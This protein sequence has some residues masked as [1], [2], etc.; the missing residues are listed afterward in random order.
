MRDRPVFDLFLVSWLVLFLELACIRWF[1][2]HVLFLTFFTNTVLL[3]CFVGMSIGCVVARKPA[4]HIARTP[5]LLAVAVGCGL[6][7]DLFSQ[8]LQYFV[9][10]GNQKNPEVVFFGTEVNAASQTEYHVP[11]ELIAAV[12]FGLIAAVMV[13]PG[14]EMGRAFNRVAGRTRAYSV[15]LLGSLAGIVT[16]AA[17][18][19]LELPPVAWFAAAAAGVGYFAL[20]PVPAGP[21]A[22]TPAAAAAPSS[23]VTMLM[24]LAVAVLL[25]VPTSGLVDLGKPSRTGWSPYYRI[26]HFPKE[27][28]VD[29]NRVSHQVMISRTAP[30]LAGYALPYLFQRDVPLADP[31]HKAWPPFRRVLIIG[32]G[33]GNDL[34]RALQWCP[35]DAVIDAVEIDPRIQRTGAAYHPD[36]PYKD[37]RVR[38]HIN[39]GRNFLRK[40]PAAEYDL[41]VFALVDSLVLHSGYSNLRLESYLFTTESFAD[42]RRVL[43]PTGLMAVYNFFRQG[44]LAARL[45][46]QMRAVYGADP[47]VLMAPPKDLIPL[48][49]FDARGFTAFF[50]GSAEV[51]DPLKRAFRSADNSFWLPIKFPVGTDAPMGFRRDQP[52]SP[53]GSSMPVSDLRLEDGLPDWGR[54][55]MAEVEDSRGALKLATDDW[56][57]L[58]VRNP[59]VPGHTWRGMGL[60]VLM[61]GLL[62]LVY[63]RGGRGETSTA[64][65]PAGPWEAG[66]FARSFFLGAGFMLVETKAVVQMA[67]LFGSTWMVNTVVFAAILVMALA[68]NLFA[69][70][71]NPRRLEPYYVGLFAALAAGLAIPVDAFLGMDRAVQIAGACALAFA[72]VAF[73]GVVFAASFR[74]TRRPDQMI[75]AN[76]A[77]ALVGGL[78]ENASIVLGFQYL[79]CVAVAFYALSALFGSR[80]APEVEPAGI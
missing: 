51:L 47:V 39:D 8:H 1:P 77:G 43:K 12:F 21:A 67:L 75:G 74:R 71:V 55:R 4:R 64:D 66:L 57:F 46:E 22:A 23:S 78:V 49:D 37:A 69:G 62:W 70:R 63:G 3:A 45:R 60:V 53:A 17:G 9:T 50:A 30:S 61:S 6:L 48:D 35:A 11:I 44:W 18:S 7:I 29:T 72:P 14:Q 10:V 26:D 5:F 68:G 40:A 32:A 2:A 56:P 28:V 42:V 13:G 16:F 59:A 24:F 80:S 52:P 79:L 19:Y 31:E 34:S 41:V 27:G 54:L 76:V 65:G 36:E 33:T 73:A 38:L 25:T 58:Y 15:N 20:R